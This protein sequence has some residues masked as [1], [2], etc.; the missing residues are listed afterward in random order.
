MLLQV[1]ITIAAI[2]AG[3]IASIAGFGIGSVLTPLLAVHVGTKLAVA[4]VSVPHL[5]ATALRFALIREHVD[6]RVFLS[7]GLTSAAGGLVGALLHAKFSGAILSYILGALLVFA[8]VMGITGWSSKLRFEGAAVWIA[9]ALSGI[10]GGLVGNQGGIRSA[11]MLGMRVSK[12]S[13]VATATAIALIV[14]AARMPIYAVT[15]SKQ[16]L[17]IW[18]VLLLAVIGVIIGTIAGERVLRKI[19]ELLFRRLV[20]LVVLGLGISMLLYPAEP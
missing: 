8:G 20:S 10:F 17:Q 1:L 5:I 14:D 4:A 7:F 16:V 11:A 19:P 13:F 18:P 2:L 9:G 6:K 12:E 15:Q 3:G